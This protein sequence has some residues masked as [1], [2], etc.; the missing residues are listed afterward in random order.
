MFTKASITSGIALLLTLSSFLFERYSNILSSVGLFALSG[1]I[2]NWLAVHML[3]EKIPFLY[4]SG[5][6]PN[7]FNQFKYELKTVIVVQFFDRERVKQFLIENKTGASGSIFGGIDYNNI[8]DELIIAISSSKLG[9][10]LQMVGGP[11]ALEPLREPIIEK[12]EAV[13]TKLSSSDTGSEDSDIIGSLINNLEDLIDRRLEELSP[14]DVKLI[15]QKMIRDHLGWLVVWGGV[16]GGFLGL[17]I[18]LLG[19]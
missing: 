3:F 2:T 11:E 8:F 7:R 6:I 4:G 9:S 5:V 1:S 14:E 19:L 17:A 15:V 16:F 10:M 12:L 13:V 18:E